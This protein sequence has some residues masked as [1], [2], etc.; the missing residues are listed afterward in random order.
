MF[1]SQ[2]NQVFSWDAGISFSSPLRTA[3]QAVLAICVQLQN[4][5]GRHSG[6]ITSPERLH[7]D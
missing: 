7:N 3:S 4:H 1:S 2:A 5:C 6:S